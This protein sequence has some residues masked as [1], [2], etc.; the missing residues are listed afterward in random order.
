[1]RLF[2]LS[3]LFQKT[4]YEGLPLSFLKNQSKMYS[5][6]PF[7]EKEGETESYVL[8]RISSKEELFWEINENI[9]PN[10]AKIPKN[11]LNP[12]EQMIQAYR[13]E[14]E[15]E[16]KWLEVLIALY[17]H[18]VRKKLYVSWVEGLIEKNKEELSSN[19]IQMLLKTID[20]AEPKGKLIEWGL[21]QR[22]TKL[23]AHKMKDQ[24]HLLAINNIPLSP[25]ELAE[26]TKDSENFTKNINY[27]WGFTFYSKENYGD[28]I[29][30]EQS[31]YNRFYLIKYL[32]FF[33]FSMTKLPLLL[34]IPPIH[35]KFLF[36]FFTIHCFFWIFEFSCFSPLEFLR[37]SA[38]SLASKTREHSRFLK[39]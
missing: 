36:G 20:R 33:R 27:A 7:K 25:S 2:P 16:Q 12:V 15:K 14:I 34:V 24:I 28:L 3:F 9:L 19:A 26:V 38:S 32:P 31:A 8:P 23:N 18:G 37:F 39:E 10:I 6:V 11:V 4:N 1:M 13:G 35:R 29:S 17:F 30:L 21:I 5:S 22:V